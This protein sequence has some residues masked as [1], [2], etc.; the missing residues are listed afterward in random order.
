MSMLGHRERRSETLRCE[1]SEAELAQ[2]SQDSARLVQQIDQL[3]EQKRAASADFREQIKAKQGELRDLAREI[4]E[5][6]ADRDV[7]CESR[8][9]VRHGVMET[10]RLDTGELIRSR[11]LTPEERQGRLFDLDSDDAGEFD[12]QRLERAADEATRPAP[13]GHRPVRQTAPLRGEEA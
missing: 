13:E 3:H 7:L 5:R 10:F 1:L 2:R 11:P 12:A 8:R 6:S 9:D 4:R